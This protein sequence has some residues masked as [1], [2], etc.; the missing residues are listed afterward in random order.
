MLLIGHKNIFDIISEGG[1][2]GHTLK[3]VGAK[4]TRE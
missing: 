4:H 3:G 1:K 2:Y